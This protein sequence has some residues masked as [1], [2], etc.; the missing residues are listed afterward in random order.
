VLFGG[1][2]RVPRSAGRLE[3]DAGEVGADVVRLRKIA[4]AGRCFRNVTAAVVAGSDRGEGGL[5]P[6]AMMGAFYVNN[7]GG[8]LVLPAQHHQLHE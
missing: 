4:A 8:Y 1:T 2:G 3:T 7:A 6:A 5:L